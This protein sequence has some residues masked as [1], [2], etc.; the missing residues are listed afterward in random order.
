MSGRY[1]NVK[2][3]I[4]KIINSE[5]LK[6][7]FLACLIGL[8]VAFLTWIFLEM[9]GLIINVLYLGGDY[10]DN[11]LGHWAILIPGI[12]GFIA[13]IL[14]KYGSRGARGHGVPVVMEAIAVNQS[15]LGTRLALT[16]IVAAATSIGAGFSLGRVG[17]V[18]LM[19]ATFGSDLGQRAKLSVEETRIL[20]G[21]GTAAAVTTAFN[22]PLGGVIFAMELILSEMRTRSFIPLVVS[23]VTAT[24]VA[25][26][27]EG[28][29]AAFSDLPV[30]SIVSSLEYPLYLILG[31]VVGLASVGFIKLLY[32][33]DEISEKVRWVPLPI[34]TTIGGIMVGM[35]GLVFPEILGNGFGITQEIMLGEN[36]R[37]DLSRGP[38]GILSMQEIN[39]YIGTISNV[40][41][42]LI[43]LFLFKLIATSI[44]VG[45]GASGG[46]FTPSLF[47][48]AS[49]GA[50]FGHAVGVFEFTAPAGAYALVGMAA[51]VAATTRATLTAIV[52]LFEMTNNYEI[53]LPLM[54]SCVVADGVCYVLSEHSV[55]TAKLARHG[56]RID[57]E[58]EQD[59]M[60]ML[61]V[62][63][64]M[65]EEVMSVEPE[66]PIEA[67]I[68]MLEDTGHM[69]FPV[70]E[71]GVL[72]G[73]ITWTDIHRAV[74]QGDRDRTV[75]EYYTRTPITVTPMETLSD[76]MDKLGK[77]EIGH[78]PVVDPKDSSKLI[79]YIT[80]GDIVR[81]YN[82][83]RLARNKM[84]WE[85]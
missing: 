83:K 68:E 37:V 76:A 33:I 53:I 25:R 60:R 57:L 27:M 84:S 11:D 1:R 10:L 21:A 19:A 61:T 52:L 51:F 41:V 81:I 70:V 36:L 80:K 24:A 17:P 13:G 44:S 29:L 4:Q 8:F 72:L 15:K 56:V 79:G 64:A 42:L 67:T 32:A 54:L 18:V 55:Y 62:Q 6:L 26:S 43:C 78:L 38:G 66:T 3:R 47:I 77:K 28:D 20:I 58:A 34:Q 69:S 40:V 35:I 16:K 73:I 5:M 22:A 71:Y 45:S 31:L 46:V 30:Y 85:E 63:E 39:F 7:N 74:E 49:I 59:L 12:G 14:I 75:S 9:I 65:T 82:R 2:Q 48:G 23:T 50:V